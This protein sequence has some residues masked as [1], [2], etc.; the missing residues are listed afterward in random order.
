MVPPLGI[1][2]QLSLCGSGQIPDQKRKE[3]PGP[4]TGRLIKVDLL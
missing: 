1:H 3:P 2:I 4:S